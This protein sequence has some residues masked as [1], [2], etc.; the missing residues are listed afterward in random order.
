MSKRYQSG[1]SDFYI[2]DYIKKNFN[3]PNKMVKLASSDLILRE[4]NE[5]NIDENDKSEKNSGE[6]YMDENDFKAN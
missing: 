3:S 4:T 6:L 2:S 5:S 1:Q